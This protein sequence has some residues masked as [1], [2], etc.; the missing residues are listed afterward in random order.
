MIYRINFPVLYFA[1]LISVFSA[2]AV[3]ITGQ[4]N[5]WKHRA[6]DIRAKS[7]AY[8]DGEDCEIVINGSPNLC[9]NNRGHNIVVIDKVK[10][11]YESVNFDTYKSEDEAKKDGGLLERSEGEQHGDNRSE[12][13]NLAVA[14]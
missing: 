12:G 8:S 5:R 4:I 11:E 13:F 3:N 1:L 9:Q 10:N 7:S 2:N 14:F 6:Y